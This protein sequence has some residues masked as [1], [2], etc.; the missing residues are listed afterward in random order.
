M[1]TS[2]SVETGSVGPKFS[3]TVLPYILETAHLR[4]FTCTYYIPI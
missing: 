1:K 2:I 3:V 4:Q